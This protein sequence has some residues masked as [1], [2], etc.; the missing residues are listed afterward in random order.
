MEN[1]IVIRKNDYTNTICTQDPE[2][3]KKIDYGKISDYPDNYFINSIIIFQCEVLTIDDLYALI[4]LKNNSDSC[5]IKLCIF[6]LDREQI[7][8][9]NSMRLP[10]NFCG[11]GINSYNKSNYNLN[12]IFVAV[13]GKTPASDI[14]ITTRIIIDF[15]G[16]NI[17]NP[18]IYKL[19]KS[20]NYS[21]VHI[22]IVLM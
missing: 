12:V 19:A 22:G 11:C 8:F 6:N 16:K 4:K 7:L 15:I 20:L 18:D 2:C 1:V 14:N 3:F 9:I 10:I 17:K 5:M 13:L 21:A